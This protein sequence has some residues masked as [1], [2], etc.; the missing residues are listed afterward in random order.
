MI[1]N[2]AVVKNDIIQ[3]EY[4]MNIS[5][6]YNNGI[7]RF[8]WNT[9]ELLPDSIKCSIFNNSDI[10]EVG[11]YEVSSTDTYF[12]LS[13]AEEGK[14]YEIAVKFIYGDKESETR[15]FEYKAE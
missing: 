9:P 14:Y 6:V 11:E 13:D 1:S 3:P 12:D 7:L 4:P 5:A 10:L 15:F 8:S 2:P